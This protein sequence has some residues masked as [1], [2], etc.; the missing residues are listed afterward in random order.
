MRNTPRSSDVARM[1]CQLSG[2]WTSTRASTARTSPSTS[3][4]RRWRKAER[5]QIAAVAAHVFVHGG[6]D[7]SYHGEDV[8]NKLGVDPISPENMEK[9]MW[10][11]TARLWKINPKAGAKKRATAEAS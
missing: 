9:I 5:G 10:K 6:M 4:R 2:G 1:V 8:A 3:T 7:V 11:N